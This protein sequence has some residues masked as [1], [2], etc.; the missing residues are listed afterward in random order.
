MS[1]GRELG[2]S[3]KHTPRDFASVLFAAAVVVHGS[4]VV[5]VAGDES[6]WDEFYSWEL[7]ELIVAGLCLVAIRMAGDRAAKGALGCLT[8]VV[9]ARW[10]A[11][12]TMSTDPHLLYTSIVSTLV[13]LPLLMTVGLAVGHSVRLCTLSGVILGVTA[14]VGS[15]RA[16]WVGTEYSNWRIG[17][18]V[19]GVT[20]VLVQYLRWW[21]ASSQR[22]D[23][24]TAALHRRTREAQTD[25]LTAL[26]NRAGCALGLE[27]AIASDETFSALLIDIDHFK[28]VNDEHGH[29]MG[30]EVLISV[31]DAL[32]RRLRRDDLVARWGG[33]EFLVLLLRT[34]LE[35]AEHI[36]EELRL[37]VE[38][39]V[40]VFESPITVSIGVAARTG[41]SSIDE[42]LK[43]CDDALYAAKRGGR[44]RV[45]VCDGSS[46]VTDD[47]T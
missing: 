21:H 17:P 7:V 23:E 40:S 46:E 25:Q 5:S 43:R 41:E 22:L 15:F 26:S 8:G 45:C 20:A 19:V 36:A 42:L 29:L 1:H 33:E 4:N 6:G 18:A 28:R 24:T 13:Y 27:E 10:L 39:Q 11:S 14:I 12:W 2:L 35:R 16:P 32:R 9:F 3:I 37:A 38:S 44:N 34:G 31:A 30:D 47:A